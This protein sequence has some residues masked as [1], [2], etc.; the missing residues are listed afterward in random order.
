MHI[1]THDQIFILKMCRDLPTKIMAIY[2][3][4]VVVKLDNGKD[5]IKLT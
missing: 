1:H 3:F 4:I 2:I 5:T